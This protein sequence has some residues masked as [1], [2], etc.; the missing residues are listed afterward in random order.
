MTIR[1]QLEAKYGKPQIDTQPTPQAQPGSVRARLE[2]KYGKPQTTNYTQQ[3]DLATQ[4]QNQPKQKLGLMDVLVRKNPFAQA[5]I[6]AAKGVASTLKGA[7][8]LGEKGLN[9]IDKALGTDVK[10]RYGINE[11]ETASDALVSD[12]ALEG[13]NTAQKIGKGAEQIGEF[14]VPGGAA[15]KIGR[16]AEGAGVLSKT[17]RLG[18]LAGLAAKTLAEGATGAGIISAQQGEVNKT[19][20][21]AGAA[22][23]ASSA[24]LSGIGGITKN[25]PKNI[26]RRVLNRTANDVLKK[27]GVEEGA[28]NLGIMGT[29]KGMARRAQVAIQEAEMQ[30]DELLK[31]SI[32]KIETKNIAPYL[33]D[34]KNAYSQIPGEVDA[35]VRINEIQNELLQ[36]PALT[37]FEA[38]KLKREIYNRINKSYGKG[39]LEIPA[40]TEAQKQIA[41]GLK[42]E[43]EKIV[44]EA[45][46]L[47]Q[48]QAVYINVLKAM[49]KEIAKAPRGVVGTGIGLYDLAV[50]G[51]AG[52]AAGGPWGIAAVAAK[53]G[54][55]SKL[56]QTGT[57]KMINY[58][59]KLSPTKKTLFYNALKGYLTNK[60]SQLFKKQGEQPR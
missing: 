4:P 17:P 3:P 54:L 43:I 9:L 39:T 40:K 28:A 12:K 21:A 10:Q 5:T 20:A 24:V 52:V 8:S 57:A 15:T 7:A 50:G 29:T 51:A 22:A 58:F 49:E 1:E 56:L 32:G 19:S 33:D 42:E 27:P 34:L 16:V 37:A 46:T 53:K 25:I 2:A 45:K 14:F 18:K 38:N 48:R 60:T 55:D 35:V 26:W 47:N 11:G 44:P 31:N 23:A 41:R 59:N 13:T 36:K 6:G 30:L